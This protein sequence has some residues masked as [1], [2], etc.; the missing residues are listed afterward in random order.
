MEVP[1][2]TVDDYQP[3]FI[4]TKNPN[5][6]PTEVP[7]RNCFQQNN[8]KACWKHNTRNTYD[9]V[10]Q[11]A[12]IIKFEFGLNNSKKTLQQGT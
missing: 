11:E 9:V 7:D 10:Y 12:K 6:N 4:D 8:R 1:A 2:T 3:Q 5:Q